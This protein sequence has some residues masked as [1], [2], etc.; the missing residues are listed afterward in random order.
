MP[1]SGGLAG[2]QDWQAAIVGY[3]VAI[4]IAG[5]EAAPLAVAGSWGIAIMMLLDQASGGN[6]LG[7][8]INSVQGAATAPSQAQQAA[9]G[10]QEQQAANTYG[11]TSVPQYGTPNTIPVSGD[12]STSSANNATG[13]IP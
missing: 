3:F 2:L 10:T 12:T 8:L 9:Q 5:T 1:A 6:T 4:I 13:Y 11:P 7:S